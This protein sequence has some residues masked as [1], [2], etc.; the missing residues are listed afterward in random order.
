MG[1]KTSEIKSNEA[2]DFP[3][4]W[5][6]CAACDA[7]W[8]PLL[9]RVEPALRSALVGLGRSYGVRLTRDLLDEV[10]QETYVRLLQN[11]RRVLR[12]CNARS[13]TRIMSYLRRVARSALIDWLR[14]RRALK[15]DRRLE[16]SIDTQEDAFE[17]SG[18]F[19]LPSSDQDP[20]DGI[21]ADQLRCRFRRECWYVASPRTT[22]IRDT[23]IAERMVVD[24]WTS[25][26]AA[27]VVELAP[28]TVATVI[29]RMRRALRE[30]GLRVPG[31]R[32]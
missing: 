27:H 26:E 24:G 18:G 25:S 7:D 11:D 5:R 23:W 29:S 28:A 19:D 21:Y 16:L 20:A 3:L 4:L 2:D 30:K 10:V 12:G 9:R 1:P 32:P 15:R 31:R 14:A 13:E 22:A 17:D 8:A 6:R